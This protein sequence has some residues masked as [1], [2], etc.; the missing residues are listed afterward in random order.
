MASM[1]DGQTP[2]ELL[3]DLGHAI[4]ERYRRIA[5]ALEAR[6]RR[7]LEAAITSP[8]DTSAR[9][10]AAQALERQ[11]RDLVATMPP[12]EVARTVTQIVAGEASTEIARQLFSIPA[13]TGSTVTAG[14]LWAV[15]AVE[16]EL[17][18]T[19]RALNAR[20]TRAVADAY[21]RMTAKTIPDLLAGRSTWEQLQRRQVDEY[22]A[23]GVTG[24]V[25][26]GGRRWRIGSY[27]EMAT[28]T[29]AA[30]AWRDQSVASMAQAGIT[31][32]TPVIGSDACTACAR[33]ADK[34]LTDGGPVG[35]ITVP[36]AITGEPTTITVDGT[37]DQARAAG[38]GHPNCRCVLIA[39]LPGLERGAVTTHDPEREAARDQMRAL[40][41]DVRDAKRDGNADEVKA[42]QAA[43][44]THTRENDLRRRSWREQLAFSGG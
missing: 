15:A 30:R 36:H 28:R 5:D 22:L 25:D 2:A 35:V 8:P 10:R 23:D 1:W 24:F 40:E 38:W 11:A 3:D 21:L 18:D 44:R 20:T 4:A 37:L 29:A 17:R 31:T 9:L 7:D 26:K 6:L 12:D 19:L 16:I 33:W 14:A 41:R 32:F 42:A 43:L 39:A 13:L 27:A 34:V